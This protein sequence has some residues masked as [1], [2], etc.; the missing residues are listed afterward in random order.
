MSK[1]SDRRYIEITEFHQDTCTE[2]VRAI[3]RLE[4]NSIIVG[5]P[6]SITYVTRQGKEYTLPFEYPDTIQK[7]FI[8]RLYDKKADR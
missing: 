2:I 5:Y 6:V 8:M 7:S 4:C 1:N 3:E